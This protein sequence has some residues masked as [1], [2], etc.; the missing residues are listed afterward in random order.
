MDNYITARIQIKNEIKQEE[1]TQFSRK[2]D[3][4]KRIHDPRLSTTQTL[5]Y[6]A[7]NDSK[8]VVN[9]KHVRVYGHN[10][11]PLTAK[12]I[13]AL[14]ISKVSFQL[15]VLNLDKVPT[16]HEAANGGQIPLMETQMLEYYKDS[17]SIVGY[18]MTNK[19]AKGHSLLPD[20]PV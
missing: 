12:A 14:S 20:D 9:Q 6:S 10:L 15:I 4:K 18:A 16:W 2:V 7:K 19:G 5:L 8:P 13:Y 17:N 1:T 11:D 3:P